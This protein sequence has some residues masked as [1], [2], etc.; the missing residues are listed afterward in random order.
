MNFL[1]YLIPYIF[2]KI[3]YLLI[4][5]VLNF[6]QEISTVVQVIYKTHNLEDKVKLKESIYSI[7]VTFDSIDISDVVEIM[8]S[9]NLTFLEF[10]IILS[11]DLFLVIE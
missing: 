11:E 8:T 2:Q 10:L 4:L 7:F 5:L 3:Q 6:D 1:K 9:P